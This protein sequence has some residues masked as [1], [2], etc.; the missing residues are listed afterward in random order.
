MPLQKGNARPATTASSLAS[1]DDDVTQAAAP[2]P[3]WVFRTQPTYQTVTIVNGGVTFNLDFVASQHP[4]AAFETA[5][6]NAARLLSAAISDR[7]VL[8]IVVGYGAYG[9]DSSQPVTGGGAEGG[10]FYTGPFTYAQILAALRRHAAADDVNFAYLP[11]GSAIAGQSSFMLTYAQQKSLGFLSATDGVIDGTV[12][13]ATD[14]SAADMVPVA[15][16]ELTHAMGRATSDLFDFFRF[17]SSGVNAFSDDFPAP[18]TYFSL[19]GGQTPLAFYGRTSDTSDFLDNGVAAQSLTADDPFNEY[20]SDATVRTLTAV[21]LLQ[22]DAL[23]FN[24]KLQP[25]KRRA[26]DDFNLDGRSDILFLDA[27]DGATL[28]SMSDTEI[29]SAAT[30]GA[31]S[32]R[33]SEAAAGDFNGDGRADLLYFAAGG[34]MSLWLMN[35]SVVG[36]RS[37]PASVGAGW[38]LAGTGDFNGLGRSEAL[39]RNSAGALAIDN[40]STG[41]VSSLVRS[42]PELET[43]GDRRFQRRRNRRHPVR[44]PA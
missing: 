42:R 9:D 35:G 28:W 36:A 41:A 39:L 19:D 43:R 37:S 25:P 2:A 16:H 12:G 27:A 29:V 3:L 20:Y 44:K 32:G 21:D 30:P 8:T 23:G 14:I 11:Q 33:W 22:L 26:A 7:I 38:T 18:L 13:F 15:L 6:E 17:A 10:G 31:P 34:A 1:D 24:A 4:T 40:L 5:V